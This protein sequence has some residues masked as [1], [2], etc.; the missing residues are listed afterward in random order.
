M[1]FLGA[2]LPPLSSL[3]MGGIGSLARTCAAD[4]LMTLRRTLTNE[5]MRHTKSGESSALIRAVLSG[6]V[7]VIDWAPLS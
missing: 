5:V 2:T 4:E 7:A 6:R 1:F 3:L